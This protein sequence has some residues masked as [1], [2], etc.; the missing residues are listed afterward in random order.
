MAVNLVLQAAAD[1]HRALVALPHRTR[2]RHA[3]GVDLDV[4]ALLQL[5]LAGHGRELFGASP[6]AAAARPARASSRLPYRGGRSAASRGGSGWGLRARRPAPAGPRAAGYGRKAKGEST[7]RSG[8]QGPP[9]RRPGCHF[10]PP[11]AEAL[12]VAVATIF[13]SGAGHEPSSPGS[14]RLL[15]ITAQSLVCGCRI[16]EKRRKTPVS[17]LACARRG[18][19]AIK[20]NPEQMPQTPENKDHAG[21]LHLRRDPHPDRP[22][23]RRARQGAHRRSRRR[24]DQGADGAQPGRRLGRA[25]RGLFRLRQPGRRGQPQRRPHGAAAGGP[26]GHRARRDAQ[27]AVRLR[28]ER[29]RRGRAGDPRRR[30]RSCDRGRRRIDD[31]RAVRDGQGA[32]GVLA[33]R[34][35]STTPRSA[36]ASSIR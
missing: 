35:R 32:R 2:V 1:E 24:A 25:R 17:A 28:A 7:E 29:G 4:E 9:G 3:A 22:L 6:G 34:P 36:G 21:S 8:E 18:G 31:A 26:A 16:F 23:C 5:Q 30:H 13:R 11:D 19:S 10:Y 20:P 14:F 33:R 15:P 27:P 12:F